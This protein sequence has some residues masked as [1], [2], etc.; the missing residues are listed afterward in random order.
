MKVPRR[1]VSSST[2][3]DERRLD[4]TRLTCWPGSSHAPSSSRLAR[5]REGADD[6]GALDRLFD[7]VRNADMA[8]AGGE[9]FRLGLWCGPRRGPVMGRTAEIASS[10]EPP[11]RPGR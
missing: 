5:R 4:P 1:T 7:A 9:G 2:S 10:A 11:D 3:R 8:A 6:V